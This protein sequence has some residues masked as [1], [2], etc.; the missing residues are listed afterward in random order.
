MS[1]AKITPQQAL[2]EIRSVEWY[3]YSESRYP[4]VSVQEDCEEELI[5]LQE[6]VDKEKPMKVIIG[7]DDR[8]K[9]PNCESG[10]GHFYKIGSRCVFCGQKLDWSGE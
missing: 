7:K 6:L 3:D 10:I 2:D 4:A 8:I 5:V 9:C 1:K